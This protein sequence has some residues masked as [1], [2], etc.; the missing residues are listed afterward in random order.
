M[1]KLIAAGNR[2]GPGRD[3]NGNV[4]VGEA[5]STTV[6]PAFDKSRVKAGVGQ[7]WADDA[8]TKYTAVVALDATDT[9]PARFIVSSISEAGDVLPEREMVA[10]AFAAFRLESDPS[11]TLPERRQPPRFGAGARLIKAGTPAD[12]VDSLGISEAEIA[13]SLG[14]LEGI[15]ATMHG[16]VKEAI[17][18]T[19]HVEWLNFAASVNQIA[20]SL[21]SIASAVEEVS[22]HAE[23]L[24]LRNVD[25]GDAMLLGYIATVGPEGV[26]LAEMADAVAGM[27]GASTI[28]GIQS[29]SREMLQLGWLQA[30]TRS[31]A[32][33]P[34][35]APGPRMFD[36]LFVAP[37]NR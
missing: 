25:A 23:S 7:V 3:R 30:G 34:T 14:K 10:S 33:L 29:R 24:A 19:G 17:G 12:F 20:G 4:R 32:E 36:V 16:H 37:V 26:T 22:Y 6:D 15:L 5:A 2:F 18:A 27:A 11:V 13:A 35:V 1:S 9:L 8:G 28:A 31:T 21:R